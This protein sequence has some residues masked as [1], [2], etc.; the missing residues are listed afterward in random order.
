MTIAHPEIAAPLTSDG[1]P[2]LHFDQLH[3]LA[4]HLHVLRYG[5]DNNL[6]ADPKSL[7]P[8]EEAVIHQALAS[9]EI[10]L[11][12][13]YSRKQ[14]KRRKDW[15]LWQQGEFKQ[16]DNYEAQTMFGKP[17]PRPKKATV[18]PFVWSYYFKDEETRKARGTCNGGPRY[19]KAVTLAYTYASCMEQPAARIFWALS[20]I[21]NMIVMG[22]DAGNA[23]AEAPPP[24]QPLYME[25]DDQYREWWTQ[26]KK[27]PPIPP[28]YVL[29]VL[30]AI[31]GHPESP[32]LWDQYISN[33]L[34]QKENFRNTTHEKCIYSTKI[35][36][37]K[38][39]F[40]RQVDDFAVACQDKKIAQAVIK[41]VG[42]YL[43]VPLNDLGIIKKFNGI[44]VTQAQNYVKISCES[45][46]DKVLDHH[47]WQ[48]TITQ[49]NPIPM[50]DD[51]TYQTQLEIAR[52][53][54]TIQEQQQLREENFN[55]RQVI[56][57]AIYA[58][59]VA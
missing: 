54:E 26:H 33:I 52:P 2:Q 5:K 21:Q 49:R 11:S 24:Q 46:L 51:N 20:S 1:I 45:F 50:R 41:Q 36:G 13:K 59:T 27:R 56:G 17:C 55:Y 18:L 40:L 23:F 16:H 19:G 53:P 47:G 43:S 12:A 8:I 35:R 28:G 9:E 30:H 25:I 39:L 42:Q 32:R 7:P 10:D 57:E 22:A 34:I 58:M 37:K 44:D 31:Q 15:D 14:L 3:M 6:W 48:E 4:H 38:V 29:P